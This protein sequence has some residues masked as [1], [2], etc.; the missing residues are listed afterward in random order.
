M[1]QG[2]IE[3]LNS[4]NLS[5]I[6]LIIVILIGFLTYSIFEKKQCEKGKEELIKVW[7]KNKGKVTQELLD[8]ALKYKRFQFFII[9]A[10]IAER[11]L[12]ISAEINE[13]DNKNINPREKE[14]TE[15]LFEAIHNADNEYTPEIHR[16]ITENKDLDNFENFAKFALK[17]WGIKIPEQLPQI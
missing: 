5:S 11:I 8:V 9:V 10:C 17:I 6:I 14:A 12:K 1:A 16:I 13:T 15:L 4:V 3:F 7:I 2:F